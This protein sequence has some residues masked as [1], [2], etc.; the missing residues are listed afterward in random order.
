VDDKAYV[1]AINPIIDMIILA[2]CGSMCTRFSGKD[3]LVCGLLHLVVIGRVT[4]AIDQS[5]SF[6]LTTFPCNLVHVSDLYLPGQTYI[7]RSVII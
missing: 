6:T 3:K 7:K 4:A 1:D 5:I 2:G